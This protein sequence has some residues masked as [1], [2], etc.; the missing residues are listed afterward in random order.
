MARSEGLT[1]RVA[2][3]ESADSRL[4]E[5]APLTSISIV[6]AVVV[7]VVRAVEE[8]SRPSVVLSMAGPTSSPA[9]SVLDTHNCMDVGVCSRR[10]DVGVCG[11]RP[12]VGVCG[13]RPASRGVP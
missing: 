7:L 1:V 9:S 13:R 4:G 12:D 5:R 6:A 2:A 8:A 3:E 10:P 11:R